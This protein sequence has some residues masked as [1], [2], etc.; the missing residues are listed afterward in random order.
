MKKSLTIIVLALIANLATAQ[1]SQNQTA[2]HR[3]GCCMAQICG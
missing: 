3:T 1:T 2:K